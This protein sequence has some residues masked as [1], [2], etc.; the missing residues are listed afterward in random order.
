MPLG[1]CSLMSSGPAPAQTIPAEIVKAFDILGEKARGK[2]AVVNFKFRY[3]G[4]K[5]DDG[6]EQLIKRSG[7]WKIE[8]LQ[9]R[10]AS[11]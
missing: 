7:V 6:R 4:G 1:A 11:H 2:G 9:T 8:L 5:T 10:D 3:E